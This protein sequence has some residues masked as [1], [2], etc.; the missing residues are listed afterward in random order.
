M[1]TKD[2][3]NN[4]TAMVAASVMYE[5]VGLI[6]ETHSRRKNAAVGNQRASGQPS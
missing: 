1:P 3:T 6:A 2:Q 4:I 5:M